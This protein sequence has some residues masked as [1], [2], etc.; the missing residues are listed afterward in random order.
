MIHPTLSVREFLISYET[1]KTSGYRIHPGPRCP[2]NQSFPNS[3]TTP[4]KSHLLT[5]SSGPSSGP[6]TEVRRAGLSPGQAHWLL[7][8]DVMEG[9]GLPASA[10]G[11][12]EK[13][14]GGAAS[15]TGLPDPGEQSIRDGLTYTLRPPLAPHIQVLF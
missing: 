12:P 4:P 3:L 6:G 11:R 5:V 1:L 13:F 7:L 9:L 2:D 10:Q 8:G 14:L 15:A